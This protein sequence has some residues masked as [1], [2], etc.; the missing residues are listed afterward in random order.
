MG[1][2]ISRRISRRRPESV[3]ATVRYSDNKA[4]CDLVEELGGTPRMLDM[5][6]DEI[7]VTVVEVRKIF[8][9]GVDSDEEEVVL[10]LNAPHH[11]ELSRYPS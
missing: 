4:L 2:L 6:N 11:V 5:I 1:L 8:E 3:I 10:S 7:A 9:K